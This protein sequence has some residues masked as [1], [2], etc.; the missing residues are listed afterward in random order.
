MPIQVQAQLGPGC[1]EMGGFW[2]SATMA[3]AKTVAGEFGNV[4]EGDTAVLSAASGTKATV[5][6]AWHMEQ[7]AQCAS[8]SGVP[9][10]A[11]L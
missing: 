2:P 3:L 11:A 7:V 4:G 1:Q 10:A 6:Q 9:V 8:E 5:W